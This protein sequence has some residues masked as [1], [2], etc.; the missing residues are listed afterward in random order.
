ME[1]AE[2]SLPSTFTAT[3]STGTG[4]RGGRRA[5]KNWPWL[6]QPSDRTNS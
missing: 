1:S 2:A 6:P 3:Y 5:R 4:N